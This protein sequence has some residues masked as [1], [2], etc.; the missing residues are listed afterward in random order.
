MVCLSGEGRLSD[1]GISITGKDR[2]ELFY[3]TLRS[4]L[5]NDLTGWR[6]TARIS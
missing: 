5:A 1:R 3:R 4:L 6:V 2:P